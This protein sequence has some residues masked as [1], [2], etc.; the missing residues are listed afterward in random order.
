MASAPRS[1]TRWREPFAYFD[2]ASCSWRTFQRSLLGDSDEFCTTWPRAGIWDAGFAYE[3]PTSEPRISESGSSSWRPLPTPDA[4]FYN[5]GQTVEAYFIR[6]ARELAK[7]Y[8][9]NGGGTTLAML[10]RLLHE[11]VSPD[12][13]KTR[14]LPTPGANDSTGGEGPTRAARQETGDT[15]G[16]A[17]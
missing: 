12:E 3:L 13:W 10:V 5:D 4:N 11:G 2:R 16:P 8:N 1:G 6:K 14:L 7:G 9:G 17:L 15:G